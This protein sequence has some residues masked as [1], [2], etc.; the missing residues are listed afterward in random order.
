MLSGGG[1]PTSIMALEAMQFP[2]EAAC[3]VV[4]IAIVCRHLF[5]RFLFL[6]YLSSPL[7]FVLAIKKQLR[8]VLLFY[9]ISSLTLNVLIFY[10]DS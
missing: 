8:F 3:V 1:T 2:H 10:F 5:L 9:D 4:V 6:F 7:N